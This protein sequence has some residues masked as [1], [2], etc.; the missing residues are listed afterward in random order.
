[1]VKKNHIE[2]YRAKGKTYYRV[3]FTLCGIRV[4]RSNLSKIEAETYYHRVRRDIL[5]GNYNEDKAEYSTQ[6]FKKVSEFVKDYLKHLRNNTSLRESSIK[7]EIGFLRIYSDYLG[8]NKKLRK[9][10]SNSFQRAF[11][12]YNE[13]RDNAYNTKKQ[14]RIFVNKL[15]NWGVK[16]G[17]LENIKSIDVV[18]GKTVKS[19]GEKKEFFTKKE[20]ADVFA[21]FDRS[22]KSASYFYRF[23]FTQFQ[24]ALRIG[25][26]AALEAG[27]INLEQGLIN[28]S[29]TK[30]IKLYKNNYEILPTKNNKSAV[31]PV[32]DELK[33]V[34]RSQMEFRE[35]YHPNS[36][37]LFV[38]PLGKR[39]DYSVHNR[40]FKNTVKKAGITQPVS[41]HILRKSWICFGMEAGIP[42]P[43]LAQFAR[44]TPQV[45]LE[46]YTEVKSHLFYEV[47]GQYRAL[48]G[49]EVSAVKDTIKTTL[50][51]EI[52][53][54]LEKDN[55]NG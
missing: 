21:A 37:L 12:K 4:R 45:L 19:Y 47:F 2:S 50:D 9:L 26:V 42:I 36:R 53:G 13:E 17:Y 31:L 49:S 51:F 33:E 48:N 6:S 7:A 44:H 22:K 39:Y 40:F 20:I 3:K 10:T 1:M 32:S 46:T 25:E 28:I 55:E 43:M 8:D 16:R 35:T 24:L 29:K 38:G 5:S 23:F 11:S 14:Q 30:S 15:I 41:S 27:D 34:L 54:E 52:V 18:R